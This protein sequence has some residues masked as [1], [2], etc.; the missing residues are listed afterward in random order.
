MLAY[1]F[2][3]WKSPH[4]E[5]ERYEE[6]LKAFHHTLKIQP[7]AGFHS[8]TVLR[9]SG[10]PWTSGEDGEAYEDWYLVENSAA[11]DPLDLAAVNAARKQSH[12]QVA[13]WAADGTGG[14]YRLRASGQ[15]LSSAPQVAYW[16]SKPAGLTYSELYQLF[17]TN[18]EQ[19]RG[20][21]WQR[22]MTLGPAREFCW[23]TDAQETLPAVLQTADT[24]KIPRLPLWHS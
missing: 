1:I 12:D 2:W 6:Y 7:P 5:S 18:G 15:T 23:H 20:Q 21:L 24:L 14:L 13:Q 10:L 11:L 3:H 4:I 16:F 17:A 22:Q 8:S 9:V 19:T